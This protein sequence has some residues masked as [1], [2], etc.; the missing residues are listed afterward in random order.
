MI[1]EIAYAKINLL[2]DVEKKRSDGFHDLKMIMIPIELHD[3]LTFESHQDVVLESNIEIENNSI[4][5]AAKLIKDK[6]NV[7]DGVKII[8]SKSIPIGAG[9]GGGSADIAATIRGLNILWN[10]NLEDTEMEDLAL[11]LGSDTL[12]CLYN[13]PAF[14]YGRGENILYIELPKIESIYLFPSAINV[15]TKKVFQNHRTKHNPRRFNRLF[16]NYLNEKYDLF[17]KKTYNHLLKTTLKCYP[18]LRKQYKDIK[19]IDRS[20]FMTG[21]G[22]TF[23]ILSFNK[24]DEQLREKILNS[25][26]ES[27]KTKPKA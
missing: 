5:H 15:S 18:E 23:Y 4:I 17:F 1:K 19:R 12:F 27:I 14:V 22:S 2:L 16:I 7:K 21:S 26:L 9:L 13:K 24:N 6:Y 25:G 10:L 11:S 8:L 20:A 3:A